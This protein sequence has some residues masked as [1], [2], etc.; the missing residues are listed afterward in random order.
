MT[1]TRQAV[2][3]S[4]LSQEAFNYDRT[5]DYESHQ[6]VMIGK[7]DVVCSHCQAKKFRDESPGICCSNGTVKI[8]SLNP[9]PDPLLSYMSG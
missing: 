9:P 7:M 5:C 8:P 6:N 2:M 4:N 1:E 3:R